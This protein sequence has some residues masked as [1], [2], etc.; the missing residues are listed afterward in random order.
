MKEFDF[1]K[2]IVFV[3]SYSQAVNSVTSLCDCNCDCDSGDNDPA[4]SCCDSDHF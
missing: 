1:N 4:G 2:M 3:S